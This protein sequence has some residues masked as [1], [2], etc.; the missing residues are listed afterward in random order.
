MNDSQRGVLRIKVGAERT[1]TGSSPNSAC[2]DRLFSR[3][4]TSS[5]RISCPL[6]LDWANM[7]ILKVPA[8]GGIRLTSRHHVTSK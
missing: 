6:Q 3:S 5:E 4:S 2:S 1:R 7:P 8:I